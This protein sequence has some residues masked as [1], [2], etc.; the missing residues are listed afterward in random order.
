MQIDHDPD[1]NNFN[2][3]SPNS[4]TIEPTR[5]HKAEQNSNKRGRLHY[6]TK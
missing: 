5:R 6:G 2:G 1:K 4:Q 3:K